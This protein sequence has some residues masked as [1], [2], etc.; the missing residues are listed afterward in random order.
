MT[1]R[2]LWVCPECGWTVRR[3]P[4]YRYESDGTEVA[5]APD[6]EEC[7]EIMTFAD[8]GADAEPS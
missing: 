5:E 8:Q 1:P 4:A 2:H 3:D 6:C 7:G